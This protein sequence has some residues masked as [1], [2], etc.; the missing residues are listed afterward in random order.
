MSRPLWSLVCEKWREAASMLMLS[1]DDD[2]FV[3]RAFNLRMEI[4]GQSSDDEEPIDGC[5][6]YNMRFLGTSGMCLSS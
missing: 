6:K 5:Y 3:G 4:L 2:A 1:S